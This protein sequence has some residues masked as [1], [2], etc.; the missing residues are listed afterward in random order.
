MAGD[1]ISRL[2]IARTYAALRQRTAQLETAKRDLKRARKELEAGARTHD[3]LVRTQVRPVLPRRLKTIL[4]ESTDAYRNARPFPHIV[5]EDLVEADLLAAVVDELGTM[6]RGEW[7]HTTNDQER[8]SSTEE[9]RQF[10]PL[11]RALVQYFNSSPFLGFLEEL[12]GIRG[13]VA[14]PHLRGGGLH[15][16]K[17]GGSLGVHADF[18]FYTRLKV[19]RRLNLLV[20]LNRDW[21]DAWGGHLELWDRAGQQCLTRIAPTFNRAVLF[22]TSNLSYHGHPHP[23]QCPE[24]RSRQSI[25]LYYYSVDYPYEADTAPHGTLFIARAGAQKPGAD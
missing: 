19:Y 18:N 11:T 6:N 1:W 22:E 20:Y 9:V 8:K 23:L 12:T 10:P 5:L 21:Q 3:L 25:A 16:I 24:D 15:E 14:D 17:R 7:H 4:T 13:L 2:P